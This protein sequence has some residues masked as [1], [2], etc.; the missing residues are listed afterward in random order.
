MHHG[1]FLPYTS[2][3]SE[4]CFYTYLLS[5]N[6]ESQT[7]TL[8]MQGINGAKTSDNLALPSA[9]VNHNQRAGKKDRGRQNRTKLS[10]CSV[11]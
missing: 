2:L 4:N 6:R 9:G 8:S 1:T 3:M 5:D 11:N 10:K 7:L